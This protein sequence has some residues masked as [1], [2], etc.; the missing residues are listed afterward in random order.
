LEAAPLLDARGVCVTYPG[1][2]R[3]LNAVSLSV[4]RGQIVGLLGP[5]GAGKS[6]LLRVLATLHKPDAGGVTI[7]GIDAIAAPDNAR[8][9]LGFLP[10]EFGFPPALT[11]AELLT[12]FALLK[13]FS[14]TAARRGATAT[15]LER[16]NLWNDR[17][18]AVRSLSGGM[19]QRLGIAIA[20]IGAPDVLIVD[21][22]TVALD[23]WERH[24]V[25]ALLL[26]LA[27]ERAVVFSTHLV[28]DVEALCQSA[29][30]LHRGRVVRAGAPAMLAAQLR[31]R[32]FRARVRWSERVSAAPIGS[33]VRESLVGGDVELTAIADTP[34]DS[35]FAL[36]EPTLEDVFAE[37]TAA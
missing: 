7:C 33:V 21:E 23:P 8:Q 4:P 18:R 22:P 34:P 28:P 2:V 6:T 19:K 26:E 1:G 30:I 20:L 17:N 29:T 13:G 36:A 5:N 14:H 3:A 35:R 15:M 31:G 16:V 11:P 9:H 12:H 10:Q 32:V 37:A 24:R 27:A 25:H